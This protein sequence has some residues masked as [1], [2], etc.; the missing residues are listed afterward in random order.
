MSSFQLNED[1]DNLRKRK[2]DEPL[3]IDPNDGI[4]VD[5]DVKKTLPATGYGTWKHI[6]LDVVGPLALTFLSFYLRFYRIGKNNNVVWDEAHFGKFG[7]YYLKHEFYHDVHPPL[8]KMLIALS[9]WLTGFDGDFAFESGA[10]YK[11]G[12]NYVFMRKFNAT[13]GAL[14]VP[15]TFFTSKWL[16]F[17]YP[18]MYLV[19]TMVTL[20]HSFIVLSKF[21]LL[22]SMLLFFTATTFACM[23]KLHNLRNTQFTRTWSLWMLLTGLSIGCVCSVKW[24]GILV[25]AVV[26]LYTIIDLFRLFHDKSV[27][28]LQYTKHWIIR[29]LD[30]ILIPFLVY[31]FC[32]KIHFALLYKSGT[33]DASTNSLFQ[34]NLEGTQIQNSPRDVM[35]GSVVTIRSHGLSPNLLHSHIQSYPDGSRQGQVTGYGHSDSNNNW[36]FQFARTSGIHLD[37]NGKTPNGELI[38]VV[39]GLTVRLVHNNTRSNLHSHEI[40]SHVS[41]GNFEVS[42]YGSETKGDEKD[43]W[44]IEIV[45][46]LRSSNYDFPEEDPSMLHPISTFFRLRHKELGCYLSSTGMAYPQWGFSQA[47]IVCKY[48][49]SKRDKST[50]WNVEDHW[51]D[52]LEADEDY[53]PPASKFWT[54]FILINFAMASSNNALIPDPD[55]YDNLASEAWEWPILYTGLRLCGWDLSNTRYYLLGSPFNTWAS[56]LTIILLPLL[57]FS[58]FYQWRRQTIQITEPHWW[59]LIMQ[60]GFPLVGWLSH[61]LPFVV[62]GRV[63]YVHHYVPALYFAIMVFGFA[64]NYWVYPKH[65]LISIPVYLAMFSGCIYIY[66]YFSPLCQGMDGAPMKYLYLEW[67][68]SWDIVV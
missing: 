63:T 52:Q 60:C 46:Q 49:W 18:T 12:M 38:P 36:Q 30:L 42:R 35:F 14:C 25:T 17:A 21:I 41:R 55:K 31:L 67:F 65:P 19:T 40:P 33:G 16:G 58:I 28:R 66:Y 68:R 6:L 37:E 27:T 54:D 34:V 1:R 29:I 64:M 23:A 56:T 2:T 43:D 8:G 59:T 61:Y 9:E 45:D 10:T 62:M 47:E 24:V 50:W 32:F 51:N 48:S 44:V 4:I 5:R 53:S 11:N 7:S 39:D 20:E 3:P 22:D 13:F 57:L 26:G 15:V